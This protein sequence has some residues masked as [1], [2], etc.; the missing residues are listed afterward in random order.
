[1]YSYEFKVMKENGLHVRV[2]AT[3]IAKFQNIIRN[4]EKLRNVLLEYDGRKVSI[5][6]LINIVSLKIKQGDIIKIY[7]E[8]PLSMA[9]QADIAQVL[10]NQPDDHIQ[11]DADRLLMESSLTFDVILQHIPSGV[12]LVNKENRITFAN[13]EAVRLLE[14]SEKDL[15][16]QK[17]DKVVPHSKLDVVLRT[18]KTEIAQRQQLRK[19]T[20]M[21]NRAPIVSEE[22]IIGA[23]AL[24]QDISYI[25][26]L[27]QELN[28][29]KELQK[30]IE[31]ILRSVDDLIGLSDDTG[32][33]IFLNPAF[34]RLIEEENIGNNVKD[35]IGEESWEEI[36]V[37]QTSHA[38]LISFDK[39]TSY[40]VRINPT[41]IDGEFRGTVFTLSP[42]DDMKLLL[43]QLHFEK[44]RTRYLE[45][46]LSKHQLFDK[47]FN[48]LIGESATFKEMISMANKVAKTDA[49]VLIT[50]ESGTGKELIAKAIHEASRRNG[51]PFIRV[52]CAAIPPQLIESELFGHEKGAFTGAINTRKGKFELANHGTIFL[53]EIGDLNVDLQSKILRVL[54]E[55][56]LERVGGYETIPLD[57]RIVA[58]THQNLEDMVEK[59]TFREDLF[60]RLNVVPIHLP[61]LRKRKSDIPLLIEYFRMQFNERLGKSING[62]EDGFIKTMINY[63]WPGNIRE[64]QNI[65]ERLITLADSD[66]LSIRDLPNYIVNPS[67][68]LHQDK[69]FGQLLDSLDDQPLRT[70]EEYEKVI[71]GHA[72]QMY[73]SFNQIAKALGVTH[74]T[75]A[76]KVRK[77]GLDDLV[78][79]KYPRT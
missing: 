5:T 32:K 27:S 24:F 71:Y 64:L 67:R 72:V 61:P 75:V 52:N 42:I 2:V 45:K 14:M 63:R 69:K 11:K 53:D 12:L 22:E 40:I 33:F 51:K 59:G 73:P 1:M 41:I 44:E 58:A 26:A 76:A 15:I 55:R 4:H 37:N 77:Y 35:I 74:K 70:M 62:Y 47:A 25:E 46:E 34:I 65:M 79:K 39:K 68:S 23:I 54:Q 57:V 17:A 3:L 18:G 66:I 60:Y 78:G 13:K 9:D 28:E 21:T 7:C 16:N 50:G 29:V 8:D 6:H 36:C 49:T 20:V 19:Y 31:L 56:E 30:E 43:E 10:Q 38:Q 48:Q